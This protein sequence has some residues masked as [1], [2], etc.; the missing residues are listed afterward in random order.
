MKQTLVKK[1][2]SEGYVFN[3]AVILNN[4]LV[5]SADYFL[6]IDREFEVPK[7]SQFLQSETRDKEFAEGIDVS[8]EF[9]YI[10]EISVT[11]KDYSEITECTSKTLDSTLYIAEK[12]IDAFV[13]R[14][15]TI[16]EDE[17]FLKEK[18][19]IRISY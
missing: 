5:N 8:T 16:S 6:I 3:I 13:K 4:K 14:K 11:G 18:G 1:Y 15:T 12:K 17:N 19:F 9:I 2:V 7:D 10:H